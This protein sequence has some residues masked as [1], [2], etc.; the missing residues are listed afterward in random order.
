M[1]SIQNKKRVASALD[2]FAWAVRRSLIAP[3]SPQCVAEFAELRGVVNMRSL[4]FH[5]YIHSLI[6]SSPSLRIRA[7]HL[8]RMRLIN[9]ETMRH[10][11]VSEWSFKRAGE[12]GGESGR[13]CC[14]WWQL[15]LRVTGV[16]QWVT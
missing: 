9:R 14:C 3:F 11:D 16:V 15:Q 10:N 4:S 2:N 1:N 13:V 8:K 5:L 6:C 7:G 12:N